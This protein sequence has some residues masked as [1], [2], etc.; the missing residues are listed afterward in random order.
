MITF[1]LCKSTPD[2]LSDEL[3]IEMVAAD[4]DESPY[5]DSFI[6]ALE[7]CNSLSSKDSLYDWKLDMKFLGMS[8]RAPLIHHL[9]C[10]GMNDTARE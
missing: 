4:L 1:L 9:K 2:S 3:M 10:V 6:K 8:F 5:K 7:K